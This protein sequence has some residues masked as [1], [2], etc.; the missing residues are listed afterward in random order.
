VETRT[1][2]QG[3]RPVRGKQ[4]ARPLW[5]KF[6][7]PYLLVL[8]AVAVIFGLVIYPLM[9]SVFS[10][11]H[12][13]D[14]LY[15]GIHTYIGLKNYRQVLLD[16][17]F[18]I[19]VRN[20]LVYFVL[21]TIGVLIIG[22]TISSWLHSIDLKWRGLFLTIVIL[23]W[24]VPGVVTGL[25]WSFIYNPTSGILD[26]VLRSMHLISQNI[27]WFCHTSMSLVLITVALLWQI[28]P[29]SSVILLA[30]L[31]SIPPTLYEAATVDGCSAVRRFFGITVPLLR[32]SLAI[33]LVQT[34]VLSIGIFDQVY[35]LTGY[36]PSTKSAV[37]QTYLYA[38]QNL[39]FGQ[40]ISAALLITLGITVIGYLYLRLIY[41][42]VAY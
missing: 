24:A 15:A 36:D 26:G 29:L 27:V 21:A 8:P 2:T 13:D 33:V 25:L 7:T 6:F 3:A 38:F 30:G 10:S 18:Q 28:V 32:P 34:A 12:V 41:R 1:I 9:F 16:P 42:E 35:V 40:G 23:P 19:A 22:L 37:I 14:L 17:S 5:R 11:L 31:E 20:T 4:R 39:N